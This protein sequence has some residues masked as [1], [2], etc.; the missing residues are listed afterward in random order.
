MYDAPPIE[1]VPAAH[2]FAV[3]DAVP[4]GQK[5]PM[6]HGACVLLVDAAVRHTWPGEHRAAALE[7]LAV[8]RHAPRGQEMHVVFAVKLRPPPE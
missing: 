1:Y 8:A 3:S 4:A 7:E 2:G 6:G 5:W